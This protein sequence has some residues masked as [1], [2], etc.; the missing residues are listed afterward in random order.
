[1]KRLPGACFLS[2]RNHL[3][4]RH[5]ANDSNFLNFKFKDDRRGDELG[6]RL[7]RFPTGRRLAGDAS[8]P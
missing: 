6:V 4:A 2:S 8:S 3:I 1:M 5:N 7:I